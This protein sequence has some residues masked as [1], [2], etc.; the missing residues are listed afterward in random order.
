[1]ST[2]IAR[3]AIPSAQSPRGARAVPPPVSYEG[4][5][6]ATCL[7]ELLNYISSRSDDSQEL[8]DAIK[9]QLESVLRRTPQP[10][11]QEQDHAQTTIPAT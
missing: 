8:V 4:H 7:L 10:E 5:V 9:W 1:M 2:K 11:P 3:K 6:L